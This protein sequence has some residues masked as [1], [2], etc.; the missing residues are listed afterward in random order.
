MNPVVNPES[1]VGPR[2]TWNPLVF[3]CLRM[4]VPTC[5]FNVL[6]CALNAGISARPGAA[7]LVLCFFRGIFF[8]VSS[9]RARIVDA[10]VLVWCFL[11]LSLL[12]V[13]V[14]VTKQ[15]CA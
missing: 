1:C 6:E 4:L 5:C 12:Y 14:K 8:Y 11:R 9:R 2:Y 10:S 7:C 15:P 13:N 3:V